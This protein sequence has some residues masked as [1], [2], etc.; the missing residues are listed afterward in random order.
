LKSSKKE[1]LKVSEIKIMINSS[2]ILIIL[3]LFLCPGINITTESKNIDTYD[4][5]TQNA[6]VFDGSD[7]PAFPA[8]NGKP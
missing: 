6:M 4:I 5:V 8:D 3:C 7:K 2:D 1:K